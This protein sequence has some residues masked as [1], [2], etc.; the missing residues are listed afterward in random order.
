MRHLMKR[1]GGICLT[2]GLMVGV[3]V[4]G[5]AG[6]AGAAPGDGGCGFTTVGGG[7]ETSPTGTTYRGVVNLFYETE[8]GQVATISCELFIDAASQGI[9]LGPTTGT[10]FVVDAGPLE[11]HLEEGE[12]VRIC[13]HFS[14]DGVPQ[15]DNCGDAEEC[16]V[17]DC[18][19]GIIDPPLCAVLVTVAPTVNALVDDPSLL[20]IEP[21]FGDVYVLGELFWDCPPYALV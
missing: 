13:A 10:G 9:V 6:P 16:E 2:T 21:T 20:Y 18:V 15:P 1:I 5:V 12:K 4:I 19:A 3:L 7:I 17:L 8:M 14:L 11:F